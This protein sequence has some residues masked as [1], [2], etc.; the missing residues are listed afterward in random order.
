M[1]PLSANRKTGEFAGPINPLILDLEQIHE[2][3]PRALTRIFGPIPFGTFYGKICRK[4][5]LL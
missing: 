5:E 1:K 3:D 4:K 2:S